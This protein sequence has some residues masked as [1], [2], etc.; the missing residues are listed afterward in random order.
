[1]KPQT[2]LNSSLEATGHDFDA[3][4]RLGAKNL[5][6]GC[7]GD[8]FGKTILI[9]AEDPQLGWYDAAAPAKVEA[10]LLEMG[11]TVKMLV[12]GAPRNYAIDA[13]Q[14]AMN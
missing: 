9:V 11:A 3:L 4:L 10:V 7:L 13:V 2:E 12:V 5:I 14:I 6:E 1:M 8:V